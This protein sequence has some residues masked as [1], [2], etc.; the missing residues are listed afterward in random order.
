MTDLTN[1]RSVPV[2]SRNFTHG[3]LSV[4]PA[5]QHKGEAGLVPG[6]CSSCCRFGG[7]LSKSRLLTTHTQANV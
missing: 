2:L 7:A 5:Y 4:Y 6:D 1:G 3:S